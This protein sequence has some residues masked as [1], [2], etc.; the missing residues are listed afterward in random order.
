[1]CVNTYPRRHSNLT[2]GLSLGIVC[3]CERMPV[4]VD[5]SVM[6]MGFISFV[7]RSLSCCGLGYVLPSHHCL[8][9]LM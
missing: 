1:M 4:N 8:G 7:V 6:A 5:I 3:F 9:L 2:S